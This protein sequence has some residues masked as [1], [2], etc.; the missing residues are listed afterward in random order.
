MVKRSGVY[1]LPGG[2][3]AC[4]PGACA[5]DCRACPSELDGIAVEGLFDIP[6]GDPEYVLRY[7]DLFIMAHLAQMDG[8]LFR[9]RRREF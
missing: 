6:Q 2:F 1:M 9:S 8:H 7:Y 4:E 3:D 5:V